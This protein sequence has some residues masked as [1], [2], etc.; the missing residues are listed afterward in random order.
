MNHFS[1]S[2]LQ[3][4]GWLVP[5][6]LLLACNSDVHFG[7]SQKYQLADQESE[8]ALEKFIV[9][10]YESFWQAFPYSTP[11][12]KYIKGSNYQL[13]IGVSLDAP[14]DTLYQQL[15]DSERIHLTAERATTNG[16]D[17]LGKV[18]NQD[19]YGSFYHSSKDK[20]GYL[21][22]LYADSAVAAQ[23]YQGKWLDLKT[24]RK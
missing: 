7:I 18:N 24:E 8:K 11:L 10:E 23:K 13:F 20:L 15:Q 21:L 14:I 12:N 17:F 19:F 9:D 6:C 16:I 3:K 4:L 1:F 22:L 2:H 5:L